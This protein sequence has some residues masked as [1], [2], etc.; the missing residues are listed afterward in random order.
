MNHL[1]RKSIYL[2]GPEVFL[3]DASQYFEEA[4]ELCKSY[5]YVGVSPF[6]G[7]P[8]HSNGIEKAREIF[9]NN[10]RLIQECSI[11]I[12][13]CNAFRGALVDDGTAFEIGYAHA[14]GKKIFGFMEKSGMLP[15]LVS[16]KIKTLPHKSGYLID[17][18][19]YLLNEDFGNGINLMM[20]IAIFS[21]GGQLV[22]GNLESV[23]KLLP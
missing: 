1:Q 18:A 22:E 15:D 10:C 9:Q 6:D 23:L 16:Q 19:G 17:E 21:S 20:E 14:L 13:N 5:G 11:V 3:P 8:I 2:A 7:E 12:A 4:R